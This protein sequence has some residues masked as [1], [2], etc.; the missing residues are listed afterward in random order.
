MIHV[1]CVGQPADTWNQLSTST[2]QLGEAAL[3]CTDSPAG[4]TEMER[5]LQNSFSGEGF[6]FEWD[7]N[8][9]FPES[10]FNF[11][12]H[13][14]SSAQTWG[15]D[16]GFHCEAECSRRYSNFAASSAVDVSSIGKFN[17]GWLIALIWV[18]SIRR[19][20]AR[21]KEQLFLRNC[22]ISF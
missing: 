10:Q 19:C 4:L 11:P 13:D 2:A 15:Q 3:I 18:I 5:M 8:V 1:S 16:N 9:L 6:T 22:Q 21:K 12:N 17:S 7:Q 20:A 14:S